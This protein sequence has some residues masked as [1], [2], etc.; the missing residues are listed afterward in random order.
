MKRNGII[1]G[2][3]VLFTFYEAMVYRQTAPSGI[4]LFELLLGAAL[5]LSARVQARKL[6]W[7]LE[8]K[9]EGEDAGLR[10]RAVNPTSWPVVG[11]EVRW[12]LKYVNE[13]EGT[14]RK[15]RIS[16]GPGETRVVSLSGELPWCGRAAAALL[17]C[18]V[19]DCLGFFSA[20]ASLHGRVEFR[21]FP[22]PVLVNVEEL[23][24]VPSIGQDGSL[25]EKNRS[26]YDNSEVYR[27]RGYRDGDRLSAVHWKLSAKNRQLLVK[28]FSLP[29]K[30]SYLLL[31]DGR[32]G[33]QESF[34]R[35]VTGLLSVSRSLTAMGYV[36]TVAWF[37][38]RTGE[39][40]EEMIQDWKDYSRIT[41]TLCGLDWMKNGVFPLILYER[42]Y[43]QA[44]YVKLFEV[45][46]SFVPE[47]A[48]L[49]AQ[50]R[51][52]VRK[53]LIL[54]EEEPGGQDLPEPE[55]LY[56]G[57]ADW[58]KKLEELPILLSV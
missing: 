13:A 22:K 14:I 54:M 3:V 20:Q 21:V 19:P 18:R 4:L 51:G 16:L 11:A 39:P 8:R 23:K 43:P 40:E 12:N 44:L 53:S 46:G 36:H 5:F 45:S 30:S 37:D 49:L 50:Y 17:T 15:E 24:T 31:L 10:I 28:E 25:Y 6:E 48:E 34:H 35:R 1:Y 33:S 2:L 9:E 47:E 26:G 27:I 29:R 57:G 42:F 52:A 32:C 55:I 7:Y 38:Y 56:A 58:E 41:E